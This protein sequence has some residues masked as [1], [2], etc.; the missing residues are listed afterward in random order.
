MP[1]VD[2]STPSGW[3]RIETLVLV[4]GFTWCFW[5]F[6]WPHDSFDR[7]R[8][9]MSRAEVIAA[10]GTPPRKA[11]RMLP[12]CRK[13]A[14]P[15]RDCDAVNKS[16]AVY[17]LAWKVGAASWMVIGFDANDKVCFHGRVNT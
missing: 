7:I 12:F 13:G 10:V 11:A 9:G 17:F 3:G 4:A 1:D 8:D 14:T 6:L 15:Y 5:F 2:R 16:G